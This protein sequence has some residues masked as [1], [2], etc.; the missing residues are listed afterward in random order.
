MEGIQRGLLKR[1]YPLFQRRR[2]RVGGLYRVQRI[3]R[4]AQRLRLSVV[5]PQL[6][7]GARRADRVAPRLQCRVRQR[8][9]RILFRRTKCFL[10]RRHRRVCGGFRRF[11]PCRCLLQKPFFQLLV[12]QVEVFV[13]QFALADALAHRLFTAHGVRCRLLRRHGRSRLLLRLRRLAGVARRFGRHLLKCLDRRH[14]FGTLEPVLRRALV[15]RRCVEVVPPK[16]VQRPFLVVRRVLKFPRLRSGFRGSLPLA[17]RLFRRRLGERRGLLRRRRTERTVQRL[18]IRRR[19]LTPLDAVSD[20]LLVAQ[21]VRRLALRGGRCRR[22]FGR[23]RRPLRVSLDCRRQFLH[24]LYAFRRLALFQFFF[25]GAL[26]LCRLALGCS[27]VLCLRIR[28]GR[29]VCP[30]TRQ[31]LGTL[32]RGRR[33]RLLRTAL[34]RGG[35]LPRLPLGSFGGGLGRV[36]VRCAVRRRLRG[37][38]RVRLLLRPFAQLPTQLVVKLREILRRLFALCN[39]LAD[40]LFLLER[41]GGGLLVGEILGFARLALKFLHGRQRIAALERFFGGALGAVPARHV[42]ARQRRLRLFLLGCGIPKLVGLAR[43]LLLLPLFACVGLLLL[44]RRPRM[45]LVELALQLGHLPRGGL[46]HAARLGKLRV[47]LRAGELFRPSHRRLL[48]ALPRLELRGVHRTFLHD[49]LRGLGK[50][51]LA[52]RKVLRLLERVHLLRPLRQAL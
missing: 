33:D 52:I 19:L 9:Q 5:V 29:V 43:G 4:F 6:A 34:I 28:A 17:R 8:I 2:L 3:L 25:G 10:R 36:L 15:V 21:C 40:I 38:R 16:C 42:L 46:H 48:K 41:C 1:E 14:R 51:L 39:G 13:G 37:V 22:L 31:F 24:C 32:R 26:R 49:F 7:L 20:R 35:I 23:T 11:R 50:R 18:E 30:A 45:R 47:G 12:Q 27:R 44:V